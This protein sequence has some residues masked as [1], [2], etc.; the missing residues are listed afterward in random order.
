MKIEKVSSGIPTCIK[1]I[2]ES[3]ERSELILKGAFKGILFTVFMA[4]IFLF[5]IGLAVGFNYA[6]LIVGVPYGSI[7]LVIFTTMF[8]LLAT[9]SLAWISIKICSSKMV[10][11]VT[12]EAISIIATPKIYTIGEKNYDR[13][14]WGGFS[15]GNTRTQVDKNTTEQTGEIDFTYGGTKEQ[16]RF[17]VSNLDH[18][19]VVSY[20][21]KFVGRTS[22]A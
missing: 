17:S 14:K 18:A 22:N 4:P 12:P 6:L 5:P 21:N 2:Q 16:T 19:N 3:P 1:V 20:L 8:W 9:I 15:L 7:F 13:T 11:I 10:L